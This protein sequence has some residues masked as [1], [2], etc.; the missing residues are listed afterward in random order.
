MSLSRFNFLCDALKKTFLLALLAITF[1]SCSS[2]QKEYQIKKVIDF[3]EYQKIIANNND[4]LLVVNFWAT[5][6]KPCVEE[7]PH[8]MEVNNAYRDNPDYKMILVSL[9]KAD[10]L[11]SGMSDVAQK[12]NFTPDLYILNDNTRMNEWIPA[13]DSSWSGAIPATVFYQNGVKKD[14]VEG[15]LKKSTLTQKINNY[16]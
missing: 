5:W 6:C 1:F 11:N 15:Q 10:M 14:F 3:D 7:L 16:L 12:V 13:I 9:D 4:K 2:T 8:F